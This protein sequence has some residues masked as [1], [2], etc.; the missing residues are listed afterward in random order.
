MSRS[1]NRYDIAFL[2]S[3]FGTLKTELEREVY[4]NVRAAQEEI[5]EHLCYYDTKR[6]HSSLNYLTPCE[7][8]LRQEGR[9]RSSTMHE[10]ASP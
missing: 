5:R 2:E 6:R 8:E 10:T 4:A 1:D 7:F 3:C 9:I